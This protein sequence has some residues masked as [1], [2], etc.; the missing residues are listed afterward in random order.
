MTRQTTMAIIATLLMAACKQKTE[1]ASIPAGNQ[2]IP[3]KLMPVTSALSQTTISCSGLLSTEEE[4]RLAFKT[5]GVISAVLVDE[6]QHFK[7]GQVLATVKPNE[8]ASQVSQTQLGVQKAQRD[9]ERAMA[10][11]QDSVATLEQVQNA[12]TALDIARQ[13]LGAV[14]FNATYTHIYAPADGF[15]VKKLA[16]AGEITAPGSPILIVNHLQGN[17][18]WILRT[19][20]TDAQWAAVQEG[21]S[22]Q[23]TFDA[24][25]GARFAARVSKKAL[26]ADAANGSFAVEMR[27][28][29]QGQKPAAGMFGKATIFTRNR[30]TAATIPYAALLEANGTLG[31]VFVTTDKKTVTR[32]QVVL[33]QLHNSQVEV[34][35]GLEQA[36]Y[37]VV[38]GSPYLTNQSTIIV[39]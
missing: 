10:L 23:V 24:F 8:V 34:L 14:Q 31:Y 7:R 38:S 30:Q 20:L 9:Y 12:K 1:K 2:P 15:V 17:S 32:Q 5:G 16:N 29:W 27:I 4:S 25:A 11:Y 26:A 3:V 21:D 36:P 39:Q 22:A 37:V 6:G 28:Q 18:Q 35:A 33:G 13:S 19:G